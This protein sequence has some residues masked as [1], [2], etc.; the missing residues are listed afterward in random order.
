MN[1]KGFTLI[2]LIGVIVILGVLGVITFPII[3][4]SI[5]T[6]K[7]DAYDVTI[8]N[9]EKAAYNYSIK[10]E[11][12]YSGNENKILLSTL[13]E[14]GLIKTA[15]LENPITDEKLKGC[16]IYQWEESKKQFNFN[17]DEICNVTSVIPTIAISNKTGVF[18]VLGWA[19]SNFYVD[20]KGTGTSYKYCVGSSECDPLVERISS[21]GTTYIDQEGNN[22][23]CAKAINGELESEVVCSDTYKLDKTAPSITGVNNIIVSKGGNVDLLTGVNYSDSTSGISGSL[24]INPTS[25]DT[26]VSGT[27]NVTYKVVDKAG[28]ET[29]LIRKIIVDAEAPLIAFEVQGN[30]MNS[31]GWAKSNFYVKGNIEDQSG[32]GIKSAKW[33]SSNVGTCIPETNLNSLELSALI[34]SESANNR[35]CIQ[36]TDNDNKT[37]EVICSDTY[38]LDKTKP[39]AGTT[40]VISG[41]L[42]NN[43]WYTSDIKL[44]YNAGSDSGSGHSRTS[45]STTSITTETSGKSVRVTTTDL[46]GNSST[47]DTIYKLDK[48]APSITA[49]SNPASIVKGRSKPSSD[50]FNK[51]KYSISGGSMSC[52]PSNTN[53]LALGNQIIRCTATGGNGKTATATKSITIEPVYTIAAVSG[54]TLDFGYWVGTSTVQSSCNSSAAKY[55]NSST[56][57]K[58][59]NED[60]SKIYNAV[61]AKVEIE[62]AVGVTGGVTF[63]FKWQFKHS[64]QTYSGSND[65][66]VNFNIYKKNDS[67]YEHEETIVIKRMADKWD[68]SAYRTGE[69]TYTLP[70]GTYRITTAS[71]AGQIPNYTHYFGLITVN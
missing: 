54:H 68:T 10:N 1:K 32:L 63:T 12:D 70:A 36:A 27:K 44:G 69:I 53:E 11:L 29:S 8:S 49:I 9:I 48:T 52:T 26:S 65:T 37:S 16:I 62:S 51:P 64:S 23:V 31:N 66:H 22:K 40:K 50:Y 47:R 25:V 61:A 57:I 5:K 21:E 15:D 28:N 6:F 59:K 7:E 56:C 60:P 19:K 35:V 30:P 42:G 20:I 71:K 45:I 67:S 14:N 39:T 43:G 2:E 34:S 24:T 55:N 18:N 58:V 13:E 38:K 46:A 41:K 17:Y 4:K 3:N 33:C